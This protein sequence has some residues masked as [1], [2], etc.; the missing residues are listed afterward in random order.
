M[1]FGAKCANSVKQNCAKCI[2]ETQ[3]DGGRWTTQCGIGQCAQCKENCQ[4]CLLCCEQQT[5]SQRLSVA[6]EECIHSLSFG[7]VQLLY[8]NYI[9]FFFFTFWATL[10]RTSHRSLLFLSSA[11]QFIFREWEFGELKRNG[12]SLQRLRIFLFYFIF[13]LFFF[14]P[15]V[16]LIYVLICVL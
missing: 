10:S 13:F 1:I 14:F 12:R 9:H 7:F 5:R 4:L 8:L 2:L 3:R 15:C 16:I 11:Q 6:K